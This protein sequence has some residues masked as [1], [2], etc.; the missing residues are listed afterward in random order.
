[1]GFLHESGSTNGFNDMCVK[2]QLGRSL[3]HWQVAGNVTLHCKEKKFSRRISISSDWE[4][5]TECSTQLCRSAA[6]EFRTE[7]AK[8]AQDCRVPSWRHHP[9]RRLPSLPWSFKVSAHSWSFQSCTFSF[10]AHTF[11]LR[12]RGV[13]RSQYPTGPIPGF[14]FSYFQGR[15]ICDLHCSAETTSIQIMDGKSCIHV[16]AYTFTQY[17]GNVILL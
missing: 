14:S 7:V 6:A 10:P 8:M 11:L 13:A 1:M 12:S 5:K 3:I 9:C 2:L 17:F 16:N 15:V 4:A